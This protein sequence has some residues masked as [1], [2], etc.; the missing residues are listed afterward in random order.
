MQSA[1]TKAK[2]VAQKVEVIKEVPQEVKADI[3]DI[4]TDLASVQTEVANLQTETQN[5]TVLLNEAVVQRN[6]AEENAAY[7]NQKHSEA[8]KKLWFYRSIVIGL[9]VITLATIAG[10]VAFKMG[11]IATKLAV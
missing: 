6:K 2:A 4:Q 1:Q 11:W 7:W 5:Q 8:L 9:S 10:I 3:K